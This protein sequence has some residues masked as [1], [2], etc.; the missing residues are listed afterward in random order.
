LCALIVFGDAPVVGFQPVPNCNWTF[1]HRRPRPQ[2]DVRPVWWFVRHS[3][4]KTNF[5][6]PCNFTR[7]WF[8]RLL[9][10]TRARLGGSTQGPD[11]L[12]WCRGIVYIISR[13]VSRRGKTLWHL[14]FQDGGHNKWYK[15]SNEQGTTVS[16]TCIR[17]E[18]NSHWEECR[19]WEPSGGTVVV[20][21]GCF[22]I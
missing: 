6:H 19:T 22:W 16:T 5:V 15:N 11:I 20:G 14:I 2:I 9:G 13:T 3:P 21:V 18:T 7:T 17:Q 12:K 4:S 1:R 8:P 10:F